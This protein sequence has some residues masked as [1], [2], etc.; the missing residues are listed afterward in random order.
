MNK[1]IVMTIALALV[2]IASVC[3]TRYLIPW[4]RANMSAKDLEKLT[5]WVRFAVRCADQLFTPEE[6]QQKKEYVLS[7]IISMAAKIG[8]DLTEQDINVLIEAAV[9]E[10]HHGGAIN[11]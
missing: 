4:I 8:L 11:G 1:D 3:I 6:W 9:N 2:S 10:I 7:Y 5:Y